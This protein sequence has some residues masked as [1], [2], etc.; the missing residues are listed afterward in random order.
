MTFKTLSYRVILSVPTRKALPKPL[1]GPTG[2]IS[3]RL[4][5]RVTVLEFISQYVDLR[6]NE[7]GAI[8]LCPFHDDQH[9]S[10]GVNDKE[11]YWHCFAGCGGGSIIDFWSLWRKKQGLDSDLVTTITDLAEMLF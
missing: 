3:E 11:N 4:K 8:G 1:H 5:A 6:P 7:G 9:P 2:P 10:F